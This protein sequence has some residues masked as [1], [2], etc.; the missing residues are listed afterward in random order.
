MKFRHSIITTLFNLF[1]LTFIFDAAAARE[2]VLVI[3]AGHGGKDYGARGKITNE[4]TINLDVAHLLGNK[5]TK[6]FDDVKVVYTRDDDTFVSLKD[7]ADIA[8]KANGNLFISIHVNSVDRRSKNRTTVKG[9]SV[10]TLGLHRSEANL[11]VAK[12]ENAVMALEDDYSTTYEG[13]DPESS[14]SYII[15]ELSQNKHMEQSI[16]LADKIQHELTTTASRADKGVRQA[17]FW[18]LWATGMPSVLVE[19]DFI[20]NPTQEKYLASKKG[21]EEMASAIFNAFSSYKNSASNRMP[22][23]INDIPM[24]GTVVSDDAIYYKVQFLTSSKLLKNGA[25]EL[26]GISDVSY[27]KENG[28]YK[29]TSGKFKNER[30]ASDWL[31]QIE[32]KFPAAFVITMQNG[33]RLKK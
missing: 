8:N 26:K 19:L 14:E 5:I 16:S 21:K 13:F 15:F 4:K 12:R 9:A 27:Y 30:E 18:V 3:D 7:R 25:P 28:L 29:Y 2:F 17:G 20:C 23:V 33:K 11:N 22:D 10:Y 32:K 24:D 6:A 31:T 1:L